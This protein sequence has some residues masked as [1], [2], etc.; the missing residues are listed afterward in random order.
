[1]QSQHDLERL[2]IKIQGTVQ[3]VGFRPFIYRLAQDMGVSGWVRNSMQ[4]LWIEV[5]GARS[6]LDEFIHRLQ[7]EKPSQAIIQHLQVSEIDSIADSTFTI[8]S[9]VD[10]EKTA[11][12]PPDLSVCSECLKELF[13][14]ANPRYRYPFINCTQCGPRFSIVKALPYDRSNTSMNGFR[15]CDRCRAEYEN[16]LDRRFH[17][18]P[19]ACPHCGPHLKL[20]DHRGQ[21]LASGEVAL[22]VVTQAIQAGKIIAVKGLGGFHLMAD[23]RNQTAM[24]HLRHRKHR[25]DKPFA[26]MYPSLKAV[27]QDCEVS[28]LEAQLLTSAEA[29][30]VLLRRQSNLEMS[31]RVAPNNPYL[32][33]LLPY[34]PLH[35]LLLSELNAP[36]VATSGNLS[37]EPI[38]IDEWEVVSRLQ[39]IADAF[40]V[41]DRPILRPIDDSIVQV[42]ANRPMMLRRSRGYAPLPIALSKP[43]SNL[44]AVG[45]HLKNTVA[46]TVG[47]NLFL[48]QHIGDLENQPTL[49]AFEQAIASFQEIYA[50]HP[51]QIA[52]DLHPDSLSTQYALQNLPSNLIPIQHHHAHIASCMTD[53]ELEGTVLGIAWDGT[54]YGTD[55]TI[56]GGEFLLAT[57]TDFQRVGYFK[58]FRLP[59]GEQAVRQ[60][61]RAAIALLYEVWGEAVF[62][63]TD[64]ASVQA[65]SSQERRVLQTMLQKQINS[66]WTSSA[67]RL[68]DA[69]AALLNLVQISTFEGQAAM[70][71]EFAVT[72]TDESYPFTIQDYV[73]WTPTL[74]AILIDL[75]R[76][77][78]VGIVSAKFHNTMVEVILQFARQLKQERVVLSGGCFQNRYLCDR[79]ITRLRAEGFQP[80]WHHRIPPNDGGIAVGQAIIAVHRSEGSLC[81]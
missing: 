53:N 51:Q 77:T 31:D 69:I 34:T 73:D 72:S 55:S 28:D 1:M 46:V 54:G 30:I 48:S 26:V 24:T 79:A 14:P 41:H 50:V 37:S 62:D 36:I 39:G 5:E 27:Q 76:E 33:V 35:H 21:T 10:G 16:P 57:L 17:A 58:P 38:C 45:A 61:R 71:L 20:W 4:G 68:F 75:E 15:M 47:S 81:V 8:L 12:I 44:L 13:D 43:V 56:W 2:Q 70:A 42:V 25:P 59:G 29:P 63:R 6:Q 52:H 67:G 66:P 18:Q 60:P 64:L 3:G 11:T 19:I 7:Q 40:L 74:Q 49:Q 80:Y 65:F 78:S 22:Q 9:S 23:A 32:G